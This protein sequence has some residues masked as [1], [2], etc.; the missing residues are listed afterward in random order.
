MKNAIQYIVFFVVGLCAVKAA[1]AF[2]DTKVVNLKCEMLANPI[3]IDATAPRFSWQFTGNEKGLQQT[4]YQIIVA[5]SENKLK[6]GEGDLW[7][8]GKVASDASILV[9]YAGKVLQSRQQCFW[10]V[11][12][13]TNKGEAPWSEAAG[14]S[15]GL[16]KSSDWQAKWIGLDR[17]FS[18]DSVSK[19]ARLSARYFRKEIDATKKIKSA[20]VYIA[21]LGLYELFING[22][23][24]GDQVLAP[25]PT[26]YSKT[27]LY[28]TF[29]ITGQLKKERTP[30]VLC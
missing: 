27:I 12:T 7:N 5:S 6:K 23:K 29:D 28:N 8:S 4:A 19:F 14:F 20:T 22:Q 9:S 15:M 16:L 13:W 1:N 18:W 3:G 26:D 17:A 10:K 25:S 30:S 2:D 24:T 21:G 11:K